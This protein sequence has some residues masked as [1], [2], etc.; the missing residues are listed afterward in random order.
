MIA[1]KEHYVEV[2]E[3]NMESTRMYYLNN[4]GDAE[5]IIKN[6]NTLAGNLFKPT[7]HMYYTTLLFETMAANG[8]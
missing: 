5:R 6:S 3:H 2:D 4:W 8:K 1:D 7:N